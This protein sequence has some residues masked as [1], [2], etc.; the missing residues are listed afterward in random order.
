MRQE[1]TV[2]HTYEKQAVDEEEGTIIRVST[3]KIITYCFY[4]TLSLSQAP[5]SWAAEADGPISTCSFSSTTTT[6]SKSSARPS[7]SKQTLFAR[8]LIFSIF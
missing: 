6:Q 4:Y 2:Q 3:I 7:R 8:L 1:G 5:K